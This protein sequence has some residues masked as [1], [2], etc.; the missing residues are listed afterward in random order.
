MRN[1]FD[2]WELVG[3]GRTLAR[4]VGHHMQF[5]DT[6]IL[7]T[8][9]RYMDWMIREAIEIELHSNNMNR[10]DGLCLSWSWKPLISPDQFLLFSLPTS[11]L[12]VI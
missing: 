8:K 3:Q 6:T 9:S 2:I 10:E 4:P 11:Q 12:D 5:Q 1:W 7:F